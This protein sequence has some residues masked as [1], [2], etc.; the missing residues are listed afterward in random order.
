MSTLPPDRARLLWIGLEGPDLERDRAPIR[1]GGAVLFGRNLD[2]DPRTGPLR[3]HTLIRELQAEW[4]DAVP[5]AVALDQEGGPVSRL[6]PWVGET[7]S[8]HRIWRTSG[9]EGAQAWGRLWG[10]GLRLLGFNVNF[11]P[12]ADRFDGHAGTGLGER[13]ASSDPEEVTA[14]AEAFLR[15]LESEGVAGCLKHSPGLGGTRVDSHRELPEL[16]DLDQLTLGRVPF[17]RLARPDRLVMVAHLRTP[18]SEGHPASLHRGHVA[19]NPWGVEAAW[20]TDDLEMGACA[21]YS[22]SERVHRALDAGHLG[23]LVCQGE[24]SQ[25]AAVAALQ[26]APEDQVSSALQRSRAFRRTLGAHH[27]A[28]FDARAWEDWA[29]RVAEASALQPS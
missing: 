14:A 18:W 9:P 25:A 16:V 17:Q 12:S 4:E 26:Q 27:G 11:A 2:P 1:A 7:P 8:F 5:L 13:C 10:E 15:G 22:W 19:G 28:P 29:A 21:A 6:R 23:L 24:A 20:V 3:C